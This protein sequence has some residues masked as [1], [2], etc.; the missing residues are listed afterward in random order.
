[1]GEI[2]WSDGSFGKWLWQLG[3]CHAE[4]RSLE[5]QLALHVG[6]MNTN[7][8]AIMCCL[9]GSLPGAEWEAEEAE[10]E[11]AVGIVMQMLQMM[12]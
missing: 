10:F 3:L 6:G 8:Q 2:D 7:T 5:L 1:M 4:D 11:L 12:A 9:P